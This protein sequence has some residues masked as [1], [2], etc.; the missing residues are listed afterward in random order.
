LPFFA[1]RDFASGGA[2]VDSVTHR[3]IERLGRAMLGA[4]DG[5]K[6]HN[7]PLRRVRAWAWERLDQGHPVADAA[8]PKHM[9]GLP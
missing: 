6:R 4:Q 1:G 2:A 3:D 7:V 8:K 5:A 9:L